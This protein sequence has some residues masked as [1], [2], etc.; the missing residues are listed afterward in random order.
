MKL[1]PLVVFIYDARS[2]INRLNGSNH[3]VLPINVVHTH[4]QKPA[5][6]H[7]HTKSGDQTTGHSTHQR[8][9]PSAVF[10]QTMVQ[11]GRVWVFLWWPCPDTSFAE[12]RGRSVGVANRQISLAAPETPSPATQFPVSA[13]VLLSKF[14]HF[15][16]PSVP[17]LYVRVPGQQPAGEAQCCCRSFITLQQTAG[18]T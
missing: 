5:R 8:R 14:G 13:V 15:N 17:H 16:C 9:S 2:H 18:F 12:W 11:L 3:N 7:T 10:A 1:V 4:A 6:T